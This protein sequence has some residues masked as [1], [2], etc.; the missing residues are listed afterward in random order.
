MDARIT[1]GDWQ[2]AIAEAMTPRPGESVGK[3]SEELSIVCGVGYSRIKRALQALNR[4]GRL[5]CTR[6]VILSIDGIYRS[7][8]AYSIKP[9]TVVTEKGTGA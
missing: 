2:A 9:G 1:I 3:T 8:P 6:R 5:V 7:V 4:E